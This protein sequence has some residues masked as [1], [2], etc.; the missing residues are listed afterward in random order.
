MWKTKQRGYGSHQITSLS[1]KS[2]GRKSPVVTDAKSPIVNEWIRF[3]GNARLQ[4]F[5]CHHPRGYH[6]FSY[7]TF[8]YFLLLSIH[9]DFSIGPIDVGS[10]NNGRL[11]AMM[12]I[13]PSVVNL[14]LDCIFWCVRKKK[15]GKK[16]LDIENCSI[17]H[18]KYN[19]CMSK[20]SMR[21]NRAFAPKP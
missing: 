18:W 7:F 19:P 2:F 3:R 14:N 13:V 10:C 1:T 8:I 9:Y 5:T 16:I 17:I 20:V 12:M 15:I 6:L 11:S 4:S 21:S